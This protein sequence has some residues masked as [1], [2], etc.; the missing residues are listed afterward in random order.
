MF[1]RIN[2]TLLVKIK[3]IIKKREFWTVTSLTVQIS[4]VHTVILNSVYVSL[5]KGVFVKTEK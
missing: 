4:T 2:T 3:K 1:F 5:V